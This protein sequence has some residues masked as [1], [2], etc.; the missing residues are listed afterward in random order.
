MALPQLLCGW[1]QS[2]SPPSSLGQERGP[3]FAGLSMAIGSR[4]TNMPWD[5]GVSTSW[6]AAPPGP[7]CVLTDADLILT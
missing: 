4:A 5:R 6:A 3:P 7:L 2:A 1:V